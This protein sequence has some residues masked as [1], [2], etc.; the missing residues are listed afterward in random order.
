M[1]Y[2]KV[3]KL[4]DVNPKLA[5]ELKDYCYDLNGCCL[6]VH[7]EL[8]PFLNEYIYQDALAILFKEKGIPFQKEYYFNVNFHGEVLKHVHYADFYC[9][10]N[11]LI[12]CK[13][14]DTLTAVQRQQL[15]NYMRLAKVKIGI[16]CNFAP[17]RE[18]CEHYYLDNL[19]GMLYMF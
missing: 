7:K 2:A 12:E 14:I 17:I 15:W 4:V 8:G 9:K 5:M 18:Q 19:T 6:Q 1:F 11:V 10:E 3:K 16:L 13:A